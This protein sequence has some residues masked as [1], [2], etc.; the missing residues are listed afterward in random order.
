MNKERTT[1]ERKREPED[2]V[3]GVRAVIEAIKADR[4]INR[5]VIQKGMNKDLFIELKE[6]LLNEFIIKL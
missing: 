6:E 1:Y 3:F 4:E 2:V 5:I